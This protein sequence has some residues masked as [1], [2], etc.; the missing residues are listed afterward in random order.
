M[1]K[2]IKDFKN[3]KIREIYGRLKFFGLSLGMTYDGNMFELKSVKLGDSKEVLILEFDG[4]VLTLWN[5]KGIDIG[6]RYFEIKRASKI[7]WEWHL[8]GEEKTKHNKRFW[9]FKSFLSF[10]ISITTNDDYLKSGLKFKLYKN[11]FEVL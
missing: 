3:Q 5:P 10:I 8:Y 6:H 1:E 4:G 7:K 2:F 11:A 9:I